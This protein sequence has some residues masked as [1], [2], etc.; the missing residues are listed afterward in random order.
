M[1]RTDRAAKEPKNG[2][3]FGSVALERV[4]PTSLNGAAKLEIGSDHLDYSLTVPHGNF[5]ID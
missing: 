5:E 1:A 3:R 2:K 4:V